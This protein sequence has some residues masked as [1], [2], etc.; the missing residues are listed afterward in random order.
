M[1]IRNALGTAVLIAGIA[2]GSSASERQ[3]LV[4][5]ASTTAN[6]QLLVYNQLGI[7]VQT[8]P[9]KGQGGAGGNSGGIAAEGTQ[10]AVVNFGSKSVTLF[11]RDGDSVKFRQ[12]VSTA[13]SPLSIAFG[14][15]HLYVLGTTTE[16]SN[17]ERTSA[18]TA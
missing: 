3:A 6:N 8:V 5:T 11:E 1:K 12:V 13:S 10:L 18:W 4:V 2:V 15:D 14:H 9:T 7:L 17:P 16:F